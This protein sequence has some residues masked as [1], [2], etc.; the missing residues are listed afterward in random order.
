MLDEMESFCQ[1]DSHNVDCY[2]MCNGIILLMPGLMLTTGTYVL[3]TMYV[4]SWHAC[5]LIGPVIDL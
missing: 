5:P 2:T 4:C 3:N 1:G